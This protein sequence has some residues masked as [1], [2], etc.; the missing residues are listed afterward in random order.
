VHFILGTPNLHVGM[1]LSML[2]SVV[3]TLTTVT[4]MRHGLWL[5][6]DERPVR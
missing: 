1:A 3:A 5:S 6:G 2:Y 4:L